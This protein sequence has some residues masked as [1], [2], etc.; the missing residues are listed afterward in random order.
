MRQVHELLDKFQTESPV[1]LAKYV[2]LDVQY[3]PF[4]TDV[5]SVLWQT[6]G[7][8]ILLL[9]TRHSEATQVANAAAKL[10]EY[11]LCGNHIPEISFG[12][13]GSYDEYKAKNTVF[14]IDLLMHYG[15]YSENNFIEKLT[16]NG[17]PILVAQ[18]LLATWDGYRISKEN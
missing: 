2:G 12:T 16:S 11:V 14:A 10:G 8:T 9:N 3:K 13:M 7:S 5:R 15:L 17:V 4:A 18:K 6:G 1:K